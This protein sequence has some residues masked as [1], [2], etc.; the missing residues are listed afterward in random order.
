MQLCPAAANMPATAPFTGIIEISIVKDDIGRLASE[1]QRYPLECF[2]GGLIDGPAACLSARKSN[3]LDKRMIHQSLAGFPADPG[4]DVDDAWG[5]ARLFEKLCEIEHR[6]GRVF[7]GF[8]HDGVPCSQRRCKL[9]NNR[10]NQRRIPGGDGGDNAYG[11]IA[12]V[13]HHPG[14]SAGVTEPSTLSASPP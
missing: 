12:D 10:Q 6:R 9:S 7:G 1:L 3:A 13:V 14:R 4:N 8:D 2:C 11:L 5:E